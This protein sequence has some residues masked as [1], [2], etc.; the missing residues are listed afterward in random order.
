M[1]ANWSD[2]WIGLPYEELGRGPEAFDCLGL[3]LALQRARFG[4]VIADPNCSV[5][6]AVRRGVVDTYRRDVDRVSRAQEGDAL[7]FLS[8]GRP[9]HLGYALDD[10]DMLHIDRI[11]GSR[12]ERWRGGRWLGKL[13]G[14]YRFA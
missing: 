11:A 7:L 12:I 5:S 6:E 4:R 9:L 1:L 2:H 14:I 10:Q 13:E 3:F 8:A